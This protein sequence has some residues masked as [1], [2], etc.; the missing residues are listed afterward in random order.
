MRPATVRTCDADAD[1]G[2]H[3][4]VAAGRHPTAIHEQTSSVTVH[5]QRR[6]HVIARD[7]V[8]QHVVEQELR[9]RV[10]LAADL[11]AAEPLGLAERAR[12]RRERWLGGRA[13]ELR[14]CRAAVGRA[15]ELPC[16]E[17][18]EQRAER[19]QADDRDVGPSHSRLVGH[20]RMPPT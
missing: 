13:V 15:L 7:T 12:Q 2:Q 4:P 10:V 8:A 5:P 14:E 19:E 16:R 9:L 17:P 11:D 3:A 18:R 1:V 6:Q 20:A